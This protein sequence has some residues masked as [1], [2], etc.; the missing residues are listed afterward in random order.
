[1]GKI[2]NRNNWKRKRLEKEKIGKG[3]KGGARG[4]GCGGDMPKVLGGGGPGR[5]QETKLAKRSV[6]RREAKLDARCLLRTSEAMKE[7]M[8]G[9]G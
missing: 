6:A 3:G 8:S 5:R 4:L 7:L 2:G 9:A 1:M